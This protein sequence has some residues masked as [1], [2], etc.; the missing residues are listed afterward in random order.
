MRLAVLVAGLLVASACASGGDDAASEPTSTTA[1]ASTVTQGSTPA[2]EC[3]PADPASCTLREL[4]DRRGILI[5][6][7]VAGGP[8]ADEPLYA[9]TLATEFNSLTPEGAYKW[10]ATEPEPGAYTWDSAD[11]I[12]AFAADNDMGIRGHTLVWP[13]S[14]SAQLY[15]IVPDY[16]YASPDAETMQQHI[17]DHIEAVV[18]RYADVT[19]R[20]DVVNEP[21]LT[22][23]DA[24]D[25]NPLTETLGEEWIVRAFQQTREL[26]PDA[27]LYV[28]E[29]LTEQPG[30]K[31]DALM[32][33]VQRLVDAGA[34]IDGVGLQGHFLAG[35][36]TREELETVLRD[37]EAL[38][39]QVAITELDIPTPDGDAE[40]QAAQ[41]ADVVEACLAS[42]ACVEITLWG[43][44]DAHSWLNDFL[45]PG[46][47]PLLFDA[48]YEPKPSY[49]AVA[50]ALSGAGS[51]DPG[52]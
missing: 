48:D 4:A 40:A 33:L 13:N 32:A 20:W 7:A 27:D 47:A 19:D 52:G 41:Y 39:L 43:F 5:G 50:E 45:G 15:T 26:D 51:G 18:T 14:A 9:E 38:G 25:P 1:A 11:A 2:A 29:V 24:L 23:G 44:T 6:A 17:D 35:A 16:V 30:P 8:L 3:D 10:P 42:E 28:N 37:W 21:L 34:P 31:H 49:H 22:G 36:P 46:W 12:S